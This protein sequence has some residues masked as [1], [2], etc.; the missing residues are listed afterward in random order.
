LPEHLTGKCVPELV[1]SRAG[2]INPGPSERV[3]NN[4]AD[5]TLAPETSCGRL[6]PEKYAST[7][8]GW[9]PV[10]QIIS[11]GRANIDRQWQLR[12]AASLP[13]HRN[14]SLLP[15]QILQREHS[16]LT[17]AQTQACQD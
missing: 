17:G 13:A 5:S 11:D 1:G 4:G 3:P 14:Q 15:I 12:I 9:P 8:G 2:S 7:A 6:R 16:D 10:P